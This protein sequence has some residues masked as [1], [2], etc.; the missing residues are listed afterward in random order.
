MP[1]S[2][3]LPSTPC[4]TP[5]PPVRWNEAWITKHCRPSSVTTRWRSQWTHTSTAWTN[6]SGT[7][8]T[9][10]TIC[11]GCSIASPLRTNLTLCF[12][13][14]RQTL[15]RPC[16]RLS[17]SYRTS[18]HAGRRP[19]GSQAANPK[20]P[21]PVQEPAHSHKTRTNCRTAEQRVGTRQSELTAP[22]SPIFTC[23]LR[24]IYPQ[25]VL[26]RLKNSTVRAQSFC[27][28]GVIFCGESAGFVLLRGQRK[29]A[30]L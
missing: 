13:H 23:Q 4:D 21:A 14:S 26:G 5:S 6:I 20:S 25:K 3:T 19:A 8:W 28:F 18:P 9:R 27:R 1:T 22:T 7:K 10:W 17:Q 16:S 30:I 12:S 2:G 29:D 24:K 11:S 15:H